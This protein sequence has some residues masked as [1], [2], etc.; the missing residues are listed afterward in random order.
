MKRVCLLLVFTTLFASASWAQTSPEDAAYGR[1]LRKMMEVSGGEATYYM[2]INQMIDMFSAQM[3]P[4]AGEFF[5]SFKA[6]MLKTGIDDLMTMLEPVYRKHLSLKDI[7][8]LIAFYESP[9]GRKF[10]AVSPLITQESMAVGQEWGTQ[11]A[12]KIL[13][14]LENEKK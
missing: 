3:G 14:R 10:A 12:Q 9:V 1:A 8:D 7:E 13:E 4:E 6:E 5:T 2:A 11:I